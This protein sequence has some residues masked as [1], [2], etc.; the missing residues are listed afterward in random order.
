MAVGYK[1]I[2]T[3][4]DAVPFYYQ[5]ITE[6]LHSFFPNPPRDI[7][8]FRNNDQVFWQMPPTDITLNA[9]NNHQQLYN[10]LN[11]DTAGNLALNT[12]FFIFG[13]G[14][15]HFALNAGP[16]IVIT[17]RWTHQFLD[18]NGRQLVDPDGND[19]TISNSTPV[20]FVVAFGTVEKDYPLS[21]LS[22]KIEIYDHQIPARLAAKLAEINL[23]ISQMRIGIKL[24][25]MLQAFNSSV[26]L[27][28]IIRLGRI[29]G[30]R[31]SHERVPEDAT[32]SQVNYS[33]PTITFRQ[34]VQGSQEKLGLL[35][36][37]PDHVRPQGTT[38]AQHKAST[39]GQL[40]VA[41]RRETPEGRS[42][43][44]TRKQRYSIP[45]I[46]DPV[47]LTMP[48]NLERQD[49]I[50]YP[51]GGGSDFSHVEENK[52]VVLDEAGTFSIILQDSVQFTGEQISDP[53]AATQ[54]RIEL[55]QRRTAPNGDT[56]VVDH[57]ERSYILNN[58]RR[59]ELGPFLAVPDV[60]G[61][62]GDWFNFALEY[63][64]TTVG[65]NIS[66][67]STNTIN[68]RSQLPEVERRLQITKK[69]F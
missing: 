65:D 9:A 61:L 32:L 21:E 2:P 3:R 16:K 50:I 13:E 43:L 12:P 30:Y 51:T 35:R 41:A 64:G 62:I 15:L 18:A 22:R 31:G 38:E 53:L 27:I 39:D 58:I 54:F 42:N 66:F 1:N 24:D 6:S 48:N 47:T 26:D 69:Q 14:D 19:I 17:H 46:I 10:I 5:R 52:G 28:P 56:I 29:V 45:E 20:P 40:L 59:A 7:N 68:P 67:T 8:G 60:D 11:T 25:L 55:F 4:L 63:K 36:P 37:D 23:D 49:L 44:I 34:G 57:W 33:N